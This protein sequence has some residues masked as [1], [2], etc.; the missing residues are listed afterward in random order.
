MGVASDRER[1]S[2]R[3]QAGIALLDRR[4]IALNECKHA[5][6]ALNCAQKRAKRS[7]LCGL[8]TLVLSVPEHGEGSPLSD[9]YEES[10]KLSRPADPN[11][12]CCV[13]SL[14]RSSICPPQ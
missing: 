9:S 7:A 1:F 6:V 13:E 4:D 12:I 8:G 14:L 5:G 11:R 2:A 10:M 3:P